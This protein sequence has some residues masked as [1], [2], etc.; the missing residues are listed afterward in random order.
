MSP[1]TRPPSFAVRAAGVWC[2]YMGLMYVV[3]L[4]KIGRESTEVDSI[5]VTRNHVVI[6]GFCTEQIT[7]QLSPKFRRFTGL[8]SDARMHAD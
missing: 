5:K 3:L 4:V 8:S 6:Q 7:P 1:F 2:P